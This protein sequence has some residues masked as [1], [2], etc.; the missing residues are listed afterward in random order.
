M[1]KSLALPS[2]FSFLFNFDSPLLR[3]AKLIDRFDSMARCGSLYLL[4]VS[5]PKTCFCFKITLWYRSK[6]RLLLV[7]NVL[8]ILGGLQFITCPLGRSDGLDLLC[9]L[10]ATPF[11][12]LL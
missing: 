10:V 5:I 2:I 8:K 7:D 4:S 1:V 9:V 6:T 12:G 11:G 3:L